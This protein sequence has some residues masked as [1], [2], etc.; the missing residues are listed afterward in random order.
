MPDTGIYLSA[1]KC[2]CTVIP[3]SERE[4][5]DT[6]AGGLSHLRQNIC[7]DSITLDRADREELNNVPA[8]A[9]GR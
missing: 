9:E 8:T 5:G 1:V 4:V 3:V 2:Q 6:G 7:A